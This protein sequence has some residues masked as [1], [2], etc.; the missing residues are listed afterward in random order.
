MIVLLG[1]CRA[2]AASAMYQLRDLRLFPKL[3]AFGA[4][5]AGAS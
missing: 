5:A 1:N 4:L 3:Q 2:G